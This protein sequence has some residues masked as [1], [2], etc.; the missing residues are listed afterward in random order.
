MNPEDHPEQTDDSPFRTLLG[1]AVQGDSAARKQLEIRAYEELRKLAQSTRRRSKP[2]DSL[3]TTVLIHEAWLRLNGQ[4]AWDG[5][6]HFYGAAARAMRNIIVDSLRKR[7]AVNA[8]PDDEETPL[9][10]PGFT[11]TDFLTLND[12]LDRL[13]KQHER[14]AQVVTLRFFAGLSHREIADALGLT[15]RT[16]DRDWMFAKAWL[17]G[18]MAGR[19]SS[20]SMDA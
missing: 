15:V 2:G 10:V 14:P 4:D 3:H 6:A 18:E 20:E 8:H 1:S 17:H 13:G 12:A 9:T 19:D 5:R 7:R 11:R 16:V